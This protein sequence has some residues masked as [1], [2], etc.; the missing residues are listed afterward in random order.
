MT[1]TIVEA[2]RW[3][4][5]LGAL[6]V[7]GFAEAASVLRGPRWSSDP[8]HSPL[9]SPAVRDLPAGALMFTDPPDHTRLRR[10]LGPAFTPA[11]IGR[12]R[13]RVTAIIDAALDELPGP[14]GEADILADLAHPAT[15]AVIA[16]LLDI[17]V[18]GAALFAD[19]SPAL[20]RLLEVDAGPEDLMAAATATTELTFFLTPILA[21]RRR[22]PGAD[23]ISAMLA[24]GDGPGGIELE[25]VLTT[26]ILLLAAGHDTTAD[27]IANSTAALLGA[28]EQVPILLSDPER[29]VEELLRLEGSAKLAGRTA[30]VD[31]DLGGHHIEAGTPVVVDLRKANRDP[32]RFTAPAELDLAR[33]AIGHLAFGAGAHFCLGA[34]LA[35]LEI[36][37]TLTRLFR[38]FPALALTEAPVRWRDSTT[39]HGM[40]ELPVR[41]EV[42]AG[43]TDQSRLRRRPVRAR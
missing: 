32:R 7:S 42:P 39:F 26:A 1:T 3:D 13:P 15:L 8:R 4:P 2:V 31:H 10:L 24:V 23:F 27:V 21:E 11:A 14:A 12:L 30:L 19:H 6:R 38:R 18:E 33:E 36:A 29:G 34:A 5:E 16:E 9:V 25:E 41:T 20:A 17:G 43:N 37:E 28:P 40:H 35:R 22:A